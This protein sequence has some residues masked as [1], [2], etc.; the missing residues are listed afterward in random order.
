MTDMFCSIPAGPSLT[1]CQ[2]DRWIHNWWVFS[3]IFLVT[4]WDDLWR[5]CNNTSA[6]MS[7]NYVHINTI[8][9]QL[10]IYSICLLMSRGKRQ[11]YGL[12]IVA[13]NFLCLNKS[14]GGAWHVVRQIWQHSDFWDV[15]ANH[16]IRR[17]KRQTLWSRYAMF[18]ELRKSSVL[19]N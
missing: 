5:F 18:T 15:I 6:E 14:G 7:H 16:K 11:G 8:H 2:S 3:Q 9:M 17:T 12:V 19:I 4:V 13:S 10:F 1:T